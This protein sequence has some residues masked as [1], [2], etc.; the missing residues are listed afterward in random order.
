[1]LYNYKGDLVMTLK[2]N[3]PVK[4]SVREREELWQKWVPVFSLAKV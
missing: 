1:M 4:S 2:H 3:D